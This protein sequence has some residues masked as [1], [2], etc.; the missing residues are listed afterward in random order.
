M[1]EATPIEISR[2]D[3]TRDLPGRVSRESAYAIERF[4]HAIFR[5]ACGSALGA[6]GV[7]LLLIVVAWLWQLSGLV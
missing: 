2:G 3:H 6:L 7:T 1:G 4:P 5:V